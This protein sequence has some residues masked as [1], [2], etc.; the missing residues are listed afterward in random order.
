MDGQ[1][2]RIETYYS[3]IFL[4]FNSAASLRPISHRSS[5]C[6][7][8]FRQRVEE[9]YLQ[10]GT[11]WKLGRGKRSQYVMALIVSLAVAIVSCPGTTNMSQYPAPPPTYQPTSP[12]SNNKYYDASSPLLG[13][14]RSQSAQGPSGTNGFYDQPAE[15][16][17]PDDFKYGTTVSESSPEIRNAFVRKVYSILCTL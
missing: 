15:G 17:L 4:V 14:P 8:G 2:A 9:E 7:Q 3:N 10:D 12:A 11:F 13:S 16:D 1:Q 5:A 6:G